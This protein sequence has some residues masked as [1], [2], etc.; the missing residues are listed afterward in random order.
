MFVFIL[1]ADSFIWY[2]AKVQVN[3]SS[4]FFCR[5]IKIVQV[6]LFYKRV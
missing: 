1:T 2:N 5:T 6:L 3:V 4:V